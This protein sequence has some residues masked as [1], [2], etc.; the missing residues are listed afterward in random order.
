M[1]MGDETVDPI[2]SR[3]VST[4]SSAFS[5]SKEDTIFLQEIFS[6]VLKDKIYNSCN[7]IFRHEA[8]HLFLNG[9]GRGPNIFGLR[10]NCL[11]FFIVE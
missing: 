6:W 10:F 3:I 5:S 7:Q 2:I 9:V 11:R 8:L 1:I 4:V